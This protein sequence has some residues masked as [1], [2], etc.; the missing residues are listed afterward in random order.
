MA[1]NFINSWK[2]LASTEKEGRSVYLLLDGIVIDRHWNDLF[3]AF[4][5]FF[6]STLIPN[7]AFPVSW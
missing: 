3:K 7:P 1:S 2:W 4:K 6:C 5:T